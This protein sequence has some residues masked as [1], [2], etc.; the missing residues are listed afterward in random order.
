MA[1]EGN[2]PIGEEPPVHEVR[3]NHLESDDVLDFEPYHDESDDETDHRN[4]VPPRP[5]EDLPNRSFSRKNRLIGAA[6]FIFFIVI[7]TELFVVWLPWLSRTKQPISAPLPPPNR[8]YALNFLEVYPKLDV[9][10]STTECRAAWK[11]L[12][13]ISC[14]EGIWT[15][16][17]DGGLPESR[18]PS[19]DRL[20]PLICQNMM[21]SVRLTLSQSL[22]HSA[23]VGENAF[24]LEGY[25]GR[26]N[27]TL[28]EPNAQD[29][30]DVLFERHAR[31]C[32]TSPPGDADGGYCMTVSLL[33]SA[34]LMVFA[35]MVLW[36]S[37]CS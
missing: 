24:A 23:C 7:A 11:T 32:R 15:R 10:R 1:I 34:S 17:W 3:M 35:Q 27:K 20:V 26:F 25:S 22:L 9:N 6:I 5:A 16:S 2:V 18:G 30:V 33:D 28:L 13:N 12:T 36:V 31:T 21:C 4:G 37:A 29:V 8:N 14:H 19:I